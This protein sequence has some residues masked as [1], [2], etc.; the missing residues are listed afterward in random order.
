MRRVVSVSISFACLF[1]AVGCGSRRVPQFKP[2][3]ESQHAVFLTQSWTGGGGDP[4]QTKLGERPVE[5]D[6][7]PVLL[8]YD[9]QQLIRRQLGKQPPECKRGAILVEA[10]LHLE[11][12]SVRTSA[13]GGSSRTVYSAVIDKLISSEWYVGE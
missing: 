10:E 9:G 4:V 13:E 8:L 3:T 1:A 7:L 12:T 5:V 2:I 6:G 11:R